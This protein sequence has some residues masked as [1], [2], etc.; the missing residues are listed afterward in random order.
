[1]TKQRK[2]LVKKH[3][4]TSSKKEILGGPYHT[5]SVDIS[6]IKKLNK[7][8]PLLI[9]KEN[10]ADA[11][12]IKNQISKLSKKERIEW[13]RFYRWNKNVPFEK[14]RQFSTQHDK[15]ARIVEE[16]FSQGLFSF[17]YERFLLEMGL[18]YLIISFE[19]FLERLVSDVY[20]LN[21][22]YLRDNYKSLTFRQI[23]NARNKPEQLL[24]L[25]VSKEAKDV[26]HEDIDKID[27]ILQ[28]KFK[29]FLSKQ[30][31]WNQ[32]KERFYRRHILIHNNLYPDEIYREK[33]AYKG[34]D[35]RLQI[36][37]QYL[38][39]S[40]TIYNK[41]AKDLTDFMISKFS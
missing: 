33:M 34:K 29:Y 6:I 41:F 37:K 27:K 22:K 28:V 4:K 15:I 35:T 30:K 14:Q 21:P 32:F 24:D 12:K 25:M 16:I 1:M 9:K 36:T 19:D 38:N 17:R 3:K 10:Q 8:L 23:I 26:I 2:T 11:L 40:L 7:D 5:F 31:N 20:E 18:V 13:N 39:R